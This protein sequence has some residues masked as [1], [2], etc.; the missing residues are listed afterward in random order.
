M[1][2]ILISTALLASTSLSSAATYDYT[3]GPLTI[4]CALPTVCPASGSRITATATFDNTGIPTSVEVQLPTYMSPI[5]TYPIAADGGTYPDPLFGFSSSFTL[6]SGVITSWRVSGSEE[7]T[8]EVL[9]LISDTGD[10]AEVCTKA[11]CWSGSG[12]AGTWTI[13]TPLPPAIGLFTTG[14]VGLA[15]LRRKHGR[16]RQTSSN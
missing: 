6:A 2:A 11:S 15:L 9:G 7:A 16:N 1:K 10:S 4:T 8:L 14:L 13:E 12:P 5:F 3:G